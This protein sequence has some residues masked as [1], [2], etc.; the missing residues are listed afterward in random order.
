L[1]EVLE[2]I[3]RAV[4]PPEQVREIR[5][6]EVLEQL[7]TPAAMELLEKMANGPADSGVTQEAKASLRRLSARRPSP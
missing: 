5:A 6:L 7:A 4:Y 2:T 3:R 1:D